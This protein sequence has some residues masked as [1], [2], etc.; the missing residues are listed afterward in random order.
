MISRQSGS[1]QRVPAQT[2]CRQAAA[3]ARVSTTLR[4]RVCTYL[5]LRRRSEGRPA[6]LSASRPRSFPIVLGCRSV[7][8]P[9]YHIPHSTQRQ[10]SPPDCSSSC[11]CISNF[12]NVRLPVCSTC[13]T[14][15]TISTRLMLTL[16][17]TGQLPALPLC[18]LTSTS[19]LPP[20]AIRHCTS[21]RYP[22]PATTVNPASDETRHDTEDDVQRDKIPARRLV[23]FSRLRVRCDRLHVAPGR[24]ATRLH[25]EPQPPVRRAGRAYTPGFSPRIPSPAHLSRPLTISTHSQ[26]HLASCRP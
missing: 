14:C 2:I 26:Y 21:S 5:R 13:S 20:R 25:L 9:F 6:H 17:V 10:V 4:S 11:S 18:P 22:P 12:L 1:N 3:A 8:P 24:P 19:R 23:A 16:V 15:S 7:L